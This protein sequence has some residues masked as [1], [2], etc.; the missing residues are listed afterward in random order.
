MDPV[1]AKA[2]ALIAVVGVALFIL[3]A[4][5]A[6]PVFAVRVVGGE[7]HAVVGTATA[8]FLRRVREVAAEHRVATGWV[9][10][11]PRAGGRIGLRF[12]G[13]PPAAQQQLRNW[14]AA[15]GW[16]LPKKRR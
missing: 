3:Q 14:W 5:R 6:R 4:A 15:S 9:S 1:L 2:A 13:F 16:S 11:V 8:A 12:A 10:G 7:P